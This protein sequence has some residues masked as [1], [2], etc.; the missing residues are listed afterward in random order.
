ML[1]NPNFEQNN[2]SLTSRG[3]YRIAHDSI[4]SMKWIRYYDR[5]CYGNINYYD[6][7]GSNCKHLNELP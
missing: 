5:S 1:E 4:R 7:M 2:Y 3:V 6:M